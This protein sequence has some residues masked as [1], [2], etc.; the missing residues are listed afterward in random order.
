MDALKKADAAK[1]EADAQNSDNS[2]RIN[3]NADDEMTSQID[4]D[5]Q[6][7]PEFKLYEDETILISEEEN[8]PTTEEPHVNW[9]EQFLPEF[10]DEQATER[11]EN[12]P[13]QPANEVE[14]SDN[15]IVVEDIDIAA[16]EEPEVA[17][18]SA[19][20]QS[21]EEPTSPVSADI[22]ET[23]LTTSEVIQFADELL[24]PPILEEESI[25][26][27]EPVPQEPPPTG[28][29]SI[30]SLPEATN[31]NLNF[32][33]RPWEREKYTKP[34]PVEPSPETAQR[35]IAA[36]NEPKKK[37]SVVLYVVLVLVL[38]GLGIG[39]YYLDQLTTSQPPTLIRRSPMSQPQPMEAHY[40]PSAMI[41]Q[42][43][44]STPSTPTVA[45]N[46]SLTS[47]KTVEA[48]TVSTITTRAMS[49]NVSTVKP[50]TP[51]S[52]PSASMDA[53]TTPKVPPVN[54]T[55]RRTVPANILPEAVEKPSPPTKKVTLNSVE[56]TPE[57]ASDELDM[58]RYESN[59]KLV[60]RTAVITNTPG[61]HA[62][63]KTEKRTINTHLSKAYNA[64][65]QG[66]N[67][68]AQKAYQRALAQNENNR[69]ALLG[70]AAI[71][72]RK[73]QSEQALQYYQRILRIYPQDAL[74]QAGMISALG[75]QAPL[76]SESQLKLLLDASPNAPYL[77]FGLGNIYAQQ[78]QWASAQ[79]AYFNAYHYDKQQQPDYAYNLAISLD[80]LGKP[81]QALNYY[82]QALQR[83]YQKKSYNF[84]RSQVQKRIQSLSKYANKSALANLGK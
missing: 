17:T 55:A 38:I 27:T 39:Y 77:H 54:Q 32:T 16:L 58:N 51:V 3:E 64:F 19:T 12:S 21:S 53:V 2:P 36:N 33:E 65:Q 25:P 15:D 60:E 18:D 41:V 70:L 4:W 84:K 7:L 1:Q 46:N 28:G 63:K 49:E 24:E 6:L 56:P 31:T 81:A 42:N 34:D 30:K 45:T 73:G 83:S 13:F 14:F 66:D 76:G 72:M 57:L 10:S 52:Q 71:A 75:T 5:D 26:E 9:D 35:I 23:P 22:T 44:V 29:L 67:T 43:D 80:H 78:R 74:A 37:R 59:K 8:E 48:A 79:Q 40:S 50:S 62:L 61:I 69:D 47:I 11:S 20:D 82:Q 68:T